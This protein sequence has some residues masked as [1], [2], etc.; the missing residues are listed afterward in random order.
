VFLRFFK[1]FFIS[2]VASSFVEAQD[3]SS[4][5]SCKLQI[6]QGDLKDLIPAVQASY[7]T[8]NVLTAS[9][10]QESYYLGLNKNLQ[11][12]GKIFF[13]KPGKMDW[14]YIYPEEQ[15]FIVDGKTLWFFQP[16]LNQVTIGD[17]ENAF[18]TSLPVS[19]LL[20][21]GK[22]SN[23]F[24]LIEACKVEGEHLLLQFRSKKE[25]P[26]LDKFFLLVRKGDLF[27]IGARILDIGG[28]DT[29]IFFESVDT[30]KL[31]NDEQFNFK[32]PS[33]VDII[34]KRKEHD[35]K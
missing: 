30:Q 19:F 8:F 11:S 21:I 35:S 18:V 3:L 14:E 26:S 16:D 17:F 2:L 34:D 22:I 4:R 7:E 25:D 15:K 10:T 1:L 27:P 9:F 23:N 24:D 13:K 29:T 33:G 20:G 5:F 31:L 28:N 32:I 6:K 12:K